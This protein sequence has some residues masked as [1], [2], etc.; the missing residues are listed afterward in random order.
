MSFDLN[1]LRSKFVRLEF[2]M[3]DG[4]WRIDDD[5]A[6]D[7]DYVPLARWEE[8]YPYAYVLK[9]GTVQSRTATV[10]VE[11]RSWR[12]RCLFWTRLFEKTRTTISVSFDQE[13]GEESGSWKGGT[14]GC[15]YELL[16]GETPEQC[17]RRMEKERKF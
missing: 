1:P 6:W 5:R 12:P 4:V 15:S 3:A 9:N 8:A 17:L 7:A 16:P 14:T 13:V 11:R 2:L 10:R